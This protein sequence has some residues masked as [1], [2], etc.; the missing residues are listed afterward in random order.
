MASGSHFDGMSL[1]MSIAIGR[2]RPSSSANVGQVL[3]DVG[4]DRADCG[5]SVAFGL[6]ST[7]LGSIPTELDRTES[8][9]VAGL[10]ATR[11]FPKLGVFARILMLRGVLGSLPSFVLAQ[12]PAGRVPDKAGNSRIFPTCVVVGPEHVV[13]DRP[14]RGGRRGENKLRTRV[15]H[16]STH[17]G[18]IRD[19]R[20]LGFKTEFLETAL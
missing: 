10:P 14:A 2:V 3:S 8:G 6:G 13:F 15:E 11:P 12:V 7:E 5:V 18:R 9:L 17:F 4:Q 1:Q 20:I 16:K 19:S